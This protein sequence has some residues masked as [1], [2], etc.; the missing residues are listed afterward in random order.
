MGIYMVICHII[1]IHIYFFGGKSKYHE[2]ILFDVF[3]LCSFTILIFLT[4]KIRMRD[5]REIEEKEIKIDKNKDNNS[6]GLFWDEY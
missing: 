5:I 1:L 6:T 2:K 3:V 4:F